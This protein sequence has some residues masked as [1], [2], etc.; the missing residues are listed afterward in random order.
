[1]A[2]HSTEWRS[3]VSGRAMCGRYDNLIA[4][5][6]Y[7]LLFRAERMPP[8]NSPPRYTIAPTD[9][10]PIIRVD[11]R[12]GTRELVMARWG[13]V[14]WWMKEMPK[15]PHINAAL[16][17]GTAEV[18]PW[19]GQAGVGTFGFAAR[20]VALARDRDQVIFKSTAPNGALIRCDAA[21]PDVA[22]GSD[23]GR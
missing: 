6:A 15:V 19:T 18:A 5:E 12:D 11:P 23:A 1:M 8:S 22:E 13:L 17:I 21:E 4:R 2:K 10:I 14:P 16:P 3:V 20:T 9:P 7:R